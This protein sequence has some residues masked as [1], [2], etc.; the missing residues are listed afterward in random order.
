[1]RPWVAGR[2]AGEHRGC[3]ALQCRERDS[4]RFSRHGFPRIVSPVIPTRTSRRRSIRI[5][6]WDYRD[7]GAYFVTICTHERRCILDN[8]RLRAIVED[9]WRSVVGVGEAPG[10]FVVM[11][12]HIHGIVW[13]FREPTVGVEQ[14]PHSVTSVLPQPGSAPWSGRTVAQPLRHG[15]RDGLEPGSLSVI[16]RAFKAAAAKRINNLRQTTGAPVWQRGYYERVLRYERELGQARGYILDN[17][18]KWVEDKNN[19]TVFVPRTR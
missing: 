15:L 17:P 8:P 10:E 3:S 9:A 19:P 7:T 18:R 5:P 13:I 6:G 1:M 14:P 2:V 16:V 11:P 12:N 4:W